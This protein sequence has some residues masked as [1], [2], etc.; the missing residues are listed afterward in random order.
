M[1]GFGGYYRPDKKDKV[2]V[3]RVTEDKIHIIFYGKKDSCSNFTE[4]CKQH[5]YMDLKPVSFNMNPYYELSFFNPSKK[6]IFF[7]DLSGAKYVTIL[8]SGEIPNNF[9]ASTEEV[10]KSI[11][12]WYP[13]KIIRFFIREHLLLKKSPS[14]AK[15]CFSVDKDTPADD[16]DRC[17]ESKNINNI[18][19][20]DHPDNR[21]VIEY[22]KN[23]LLSTTSLRCSACNGYSCFCNPVTSKDL[24]G[25]S[26]NPV[27]SKDLLL[28][29]YID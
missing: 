28:L 16:V 6:S 17:L 20:V 15:I 18:V 5:C 4:W 22:V 11:C 24:I 19:I 13:N 9:D 12:R 2:P 25:Y 10:I 1:C 23:H 14:N 21:I 29:N 26:C 7:K 27:T 8:A 3:W